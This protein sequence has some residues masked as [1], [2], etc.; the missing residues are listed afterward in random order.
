M[1]DGFDIVASSVVE[2]DRARITE[3]ITALEKENENISVEYRVRHKNGEIRHVMGN[4]K[5][6]LE[7]G[8]LI[9]QRFL[10][11]CTAQKLQAQRNMQNN[12]VINDMRIFLCQFFLEIFHGN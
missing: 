3:Y 4:V 6:L 9:Y 8:E 2:E 11:D 5:L 10:L 12:P 7:D 1:A